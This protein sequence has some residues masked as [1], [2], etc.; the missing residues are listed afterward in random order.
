M[1]ILL[2]AALLLTLA[3]AVPAA[4]AE[5]PPG[6]SCHVVEEYVT[7]AHTSGRVTDGTFTVSPGAPRPVECYY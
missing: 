1:R 7:E 6:G 4:Q 2:L 3:A 5:D